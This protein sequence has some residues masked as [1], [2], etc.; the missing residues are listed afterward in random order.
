MYAIMVVTI[1][2]ALQ[3]GIFSVIGVRQ[4][5]KMFDRQ[6]DANLLSLNENYIDS[7]I[8]DLYQKKVF[9][10]TRF[11]MSKNDSINLSLN[12]KDS[13][14]QLEMKGVV[15]KSTKIIDF[16]V[17][18]FLYHLKPAT[19]QYLFGSQLQVN[20]YLSTISK[21]PIV[22]KKAPKYAGEALVSNAKIDS[23]KTEA[24]HWM[25][26]LDKEII[27]KIEGRDQFSQSNWWS[28][29]MFWWREDL[30]NFK[31]IKKAIL[32][33]VPE[34]HPEIRVVVSESEAKAIYR[35]L[36]VKPF[37]GIRL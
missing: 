7:N 17:D 22:I 33:T 20:S 27:L 37:V 34:Y 15:I 26:C 2:I 30:N 8:V 29:H 6:V 32:F 21:A 18:Q 4:K 31:K 1:G 36:P 16:E 12:L 5:M 14:L 3:Y 23:V 13:L 9:L 24:V 19:Y 35:A 11:Q 25:L 10:E 28:G